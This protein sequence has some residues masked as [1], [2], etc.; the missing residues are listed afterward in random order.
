MNTRICLGIMLAG[1]LVAGAPRQAQM[2]GGGAMHG[3]IGG[4]G[5]AVG[6]GVAGVGAAGGGA[7]TSCW[8][9]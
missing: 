4:P 9:V 6:A 2:R 3:A 8:R 5:G 1:A 7:A